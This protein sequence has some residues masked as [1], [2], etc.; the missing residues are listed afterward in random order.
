MERKQ[1]AVMQDRIGA[2]RADIF[3]LRVMGLFHPIADAIKMIVKEDFTPAAANKFV[4]VT[5]PFLAVFFALVG[6]ATI[7]FGGSVRVGDRVIQ[8]QVVDLNVGLLYV[9]A[10]ISLGVYGFILS[11]WAS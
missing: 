3:G 5:S 2:N 8:L 9:F 7:P 1:S 10:M 6:F 11:G 4:Y